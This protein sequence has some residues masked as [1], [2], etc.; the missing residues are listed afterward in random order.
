MYLQESIDF[1]KY[2]AI[3]IDEIF[4]VDHVLMTKLICKL[5]TFNGIIIMLGHSSQNGCISN[6]K[7]G[8]SKCNANG[9]IVG[10]NYFK[11][12]DE[13]MI[14]KAATG[15][16]RYDLKTLEKLKHLQENKNLDGFEFKQ[17][18]RDLKTNIC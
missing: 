16:C 2:E 5:R 11:F 8:Y 13:E 18:K 15:K 1:D 12:T 4:R 6:E 14:E 10:L 3:V 9:E 17:I 7:Y